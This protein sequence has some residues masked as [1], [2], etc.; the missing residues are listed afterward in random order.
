MDSR[1]KMDNKRGVVIVVSEAIGADEV[2]EV[3]EEAGEVGSQR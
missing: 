1:S 3:I 2:V